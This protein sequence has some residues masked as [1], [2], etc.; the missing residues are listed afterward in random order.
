[1]IAGKCVR[2]C[3]CV[4]V[5]I[6]CV[7]CNHPR[8]AV[9]VCAVYFAIMCFADKVFCAILKRIIIRFT[10]KFLLSCKNNYL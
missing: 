3:V 7:A 8:P 10:T 5:F 2:L 4:R 6:I 1:M 9:F